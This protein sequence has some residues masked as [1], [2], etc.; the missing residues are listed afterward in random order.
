[1]CYTPRILI[2]SPMKYIYSIHIK[3]CFCSIYIIFYK[4]AELQG[5]R[6][7]EEGALSLLVRGVKQLGSILCGNLKSEVCKLY[8]FLNVKAD[9]AWLP[10]LKKKMEEEKAK[11]QNEFS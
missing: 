6:Q 11:I 8:K 9:L 1:M 7:T 4:F 3:G 2:D 10:Y 5:C